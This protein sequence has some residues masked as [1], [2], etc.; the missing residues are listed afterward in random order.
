MFMHPTLAINFALIL[1]FGFFSTYWDIKKGIVKNKLIAVMLVSAFF[2]HLASILIFPSLLDA[3]PMMTLNLC[4]SIFVSIL[5]YIVNIWPAGDSKLFIAYASL[6]PLSVFVPS[7][8]PFLSV[9]FLINTF[10]P[11]FLAMF[12]FL[13]IK[14]KPSE[15]K[16]S[17][18]FTFNPYT[19]FMVF[20][21]LIGFMWFIEN[22]FAFLGMFMNYFIMIIFLFVI[23]EIF[24]KIVPFNMEYVYLFLLVLRLILDYRSVFTIG[25][26]YELLG[27]VFAFVIL[28][29]FVIDLG[30]H[31]FTVPKKIDDLEPGMCLAEG[32][33]TSQEPGVKYEKKRLIYFSEIQA[34]M[35]R[36]RVKFI[37]SVSFS[38]LNKEDVEKIKKLRKNGDIPFDEVMIHV[39][40]PFASFL[41]LGIV[42]TIL[43]QTNFVAF[44]KYMYF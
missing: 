11:V 4:F 25:Y 10:V 29:Y 21:V 22:A 38:G 28:R 32:I 43:L 26:A 9:D 35:E 12:I 20:I 5:L 14:S 6:I 1:A 19:I 18:K 36:G 37:H 8:Q 13:M 24:N 41:F 31:G 23:L 7:G 17:L 15:I 33:A 44:I 39:K 3:L 42:L 27:I 40:T 34:L 30:F 2:A 16:K